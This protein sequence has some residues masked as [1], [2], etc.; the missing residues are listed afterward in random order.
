MAAKPKPEAPDDKGDP[1][2][3]AGAE[4]RNADYLE[5]LAAGKAYRIPAA[6]E[7]AKED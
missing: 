7:P 4:D 3:I 1:F 5:K 2:D 6:P